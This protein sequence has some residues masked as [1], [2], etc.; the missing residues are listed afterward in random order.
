MRA[1]QTGSPRRLRYLAHATRAGRESLSVV[2]G[3]D[4]RPAVSPQGLGVPAG[5]ARDQ[6]PVSLHLTDTLPFRC[7]WAGRGRS[8]PYRPAPRMPIGGK[9]PACHG[10]HRPQGEAPP[11][12]AFGS[13]TS[14]EIDQETE[15]DSKSGPTS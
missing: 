6:A 13:G 3:D 14:R 12:S 8:S 1:R 9:E 15:T 5:S 10:G 11:G 2:T 4:M 7:W